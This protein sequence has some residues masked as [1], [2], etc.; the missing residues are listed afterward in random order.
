[1]GNCL[2]LGVGNYLAP[3][4]GNYLALEGFRLGDCLVADTLVGRAADGPLFIRE[5]PDHWPEDLDIQPSTA[6]A[7]PMKK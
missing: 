3:P 4:L 5:R 1:V 7:T 2:T 6:I